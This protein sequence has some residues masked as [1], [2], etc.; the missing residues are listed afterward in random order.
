M[1]QRARRCQAQSKAIAEVRAVAAEDDT[2]GYRRV[3]KRLDQK[4]IEIG[5]ECVRRL[6]GEMDL[7]PP[8]PAKKARPTH[9]VVAEQAWPDGRRLQI[10][11]TRFKLDD[12]RIGVNVARYFRFEGSRYA[13][14]WEENHGRLGSANVLSVRDCGRH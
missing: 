7:Q 2:Y 3:H 1:S 4:G 9:E 12:G 5:R 14:I 13:D 10:D 6:M 8:P 11:A